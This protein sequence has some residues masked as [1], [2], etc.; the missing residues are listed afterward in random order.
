MRIGISGNWRD[1]LSEHK[2]N[3]V[4]V[5]CIAENGGTPLVLPVVE[6][7][8]V[9]SSCLDNID[10]LLL[11][12]GGDIDPRYWGEQLTAMSNTPSARRD[13]FDMCLTRMAVA[14][15]IRTLG[16]CRGLQA[17]AIVSGGTIFQDIYK[18]HP[19]RKLIGHSQKAPRTETSHE[20]TIEQGSLLSEVMGCGRVMVNSFHHQAVRSTGDTCQV[21]ARS[22]DGIIEAIE[23]PSLPILAVQ[24]HPEE[25][26]SSHDAHRRLFRWLINK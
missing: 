11:T 12:G 9:I 17:L 6:N 21:V 2:L 18:H 8:E 10:A 20:V 26:F 23:F 13:T 22:D 5:R 19:G 3:D 4:Y 16:I 24:W 7:E 14:R 25:L 15:G 1:D